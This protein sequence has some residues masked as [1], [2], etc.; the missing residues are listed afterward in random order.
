MHQTLK[1]ELVLFS[2]L[3]DGGRGKK[4][5]DL[6]RAAGVTLY[7]CRLQ[8]SPQ[9]AKLTQASGSYPSLIQGLAHGG[10]DQFGLL[11]PVLLCGFCLLP[12]LVK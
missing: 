6:P 5:E 2:C 1:P 10:G 11:S 9:A 4:Q 7:S 3:R 12:E 8:D